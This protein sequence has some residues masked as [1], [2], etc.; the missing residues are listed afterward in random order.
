MVFWPK[1]SKT[2]LEQ[3]NTWMVKLFDK[4]EELV[5]AA[6]RKTAD[7]GLVMKVQQHMKHE[8]E[9]MDG[10]I[11][12]GKEIDLV[13]AALLVEAVK[14]DT[15]SE[16]PENMVVGLCPRWALARRMLICSQWRMRSWRSAPAV[17]P[18]PPGSR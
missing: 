9:I 6:A 1:H 11:R 17:A 13:K 15:V 3:A 2:C 8:R 12:D 7:T 4:F 10:L 16:F 14:A 5:I 18:R